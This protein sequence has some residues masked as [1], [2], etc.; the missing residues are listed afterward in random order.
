VASDVPDYALMMGVPAL[1]K[2][3]DEPARPSP[4]RKRQ[5][6]QFHLFGE[7]MEIPGSFAGRAALS[8]LGRGRATETGRP[9]MIS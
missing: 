6:R 3:L 7:P 9:F 2:M 1:Q 4:D 8:Q 5:G